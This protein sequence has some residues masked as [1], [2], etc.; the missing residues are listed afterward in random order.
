M[1]CT[2]CIKRSF[3]DQSGQSYKE[4]PLCHQS[5]ARGMIK[6]VLGRGAIN[7]I[8]EE[9]RAKVELEVQGELERRARAEKDMNQYKD[10]ARTLYNDLCDCLNLRCPRCKMV[11]ND[12]DGCNALR[13]G[14]P[15]CRAAFCAVCLQDCGNDA[16]SHAGKHGNLFDKSL[17]ENGK[18]IR[19]STQAK[20]FFEKIS[21]EPFEIQQLVKNWYKDSCNT[22]SSKPLDSQQI[23]RS[24]VEQSL[25]QLQ[26]AIKS[27]RLGV[28]CNCEDDTYRRSGLSFEHISPRCMIPEDYKLELVPSGEDSIS[29]VVLSRKENVDLY[30]RT[31][32]RRMDITQFNEESDLDGE[33]P[34]VDALINVVLALKCGV[35]AFEGATS[36]YQS[37]GCMRRKN[38][39]Q[40]ENDEISINLNQVRQNGE[41]GNDVEIIIPRSRIIGINQ[42]QRLLLLER[43]LKNSEPSAIMFDALRDF[44]SSRK[45]KRIFDEISVPAPETFNELNHNQRRVAHPLS[46]KTAIETAGP[47][48]TGKTKTITELIRCILECTDASVI[49]LSERNGAIDAIAEKFASR[50]LKQKRN[51]LHEILDMTMWNNV[52][53]FGS[54]G[55]IGPST[56]LF[57][58]DAKLR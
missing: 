1:L 30:G 4:C 17:F 41:M 5:I 50:C 14:N 18:R 58:L 38:S 55:G 3:D 12:Y 33:R 9:L 29:R 15:D 48:G 42:N 35:I 47:P 39:R 22:P 56:G 32:W 37:S 8:E 24:F 57:T 54:K 34:K 26:I 53:T 10:R 25:E 2:P 21:E 46:L 43:H 7:A 40:L 36:L 27:D 31:Q 11:F 23:D 13:C 51:G 44:V 19:M 16:H 28:L 52:L 49:V 20:R 6:D 45:P